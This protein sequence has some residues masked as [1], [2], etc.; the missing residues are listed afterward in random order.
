MY[1]P[2]KHLLECTGR[3]SL[4][5]THTLKLLY[6]LLSACQLPVLSFLP[7]TPYPFSTIVH[8]SGQ[9]SSLGITLNSSL[10]PASHKPQQTLP[11]HPSSCAS[12]R[13]STSAAHPDPTAASAPSLIPLAHAP[14][15]GPR[16]PFKVQLWACCSSSENHSKGP[17]APSRKFKFLITAEQAFPSVSGLISTPK[18]S[19][20]ESS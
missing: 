2:E 4:L 17:T 20:F 1:L 6:P 8:P 16:D 7:P 19:V 12:S 18:D 15:Q 10:S 11:A 3:M 13:L 9:Q 14:P 5:S